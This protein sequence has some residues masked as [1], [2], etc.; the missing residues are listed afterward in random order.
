MKTKEQVT[1]WEQALIKSGFRMTLSRKVILELFAKS[2]GHLNAK[3][4][5]LK[6]NKK[7]P[8]IGLT[9]VYRTLE[10]LVRLKI[11]SRFEFGD[12]QNSYELKSESMNYHHH[13]ICSS[14]GKVIN[15][16]GCI[17]EGKA[18]F[19]KIQEYL[20]SKYGFHGEGFGVQVYGLCNSCKLVSPGE[21]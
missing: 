10:L 12:G 9:T 11:L 4:V 16:N 19:E 21:R 13:L 1:H 18:F 14:C 15:C 17:D 6:I 7:H 3:E 8:E 5:Y 20:S 2:K